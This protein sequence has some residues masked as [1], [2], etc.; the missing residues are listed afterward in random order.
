MSD[1]EKGYM[2]GFNN[3]LRLADA[4]EEVINTKS[5]IGV[6]AGDPC[7]I[8]PWRDG[9]H[10]TL[11]PLN[12]NLPYCGLIEEE[13][14]RYTQAETEQLKVL[15]MDFPVSILDKAEAQ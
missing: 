3:A 12:G 1:G 15:L 7:A 11:H 8:T 5:P 2:E 9:K 13:F 4:V 14:R 10:F 6:H